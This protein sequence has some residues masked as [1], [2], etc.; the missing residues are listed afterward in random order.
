MDAPFDGAKISLCNPNG[1]QGGSYMTKI[2]YGDTPGLYFQT[3]KLETKQGII[4]TDKKHYFDI[5]I[6]SNNSEIISWVESLEECLQE[7]IYEKRK[8][9]FETELDMEDI[10]NTMTPILRPYKGGKY[11]LMRI[12]IPTVKNIVGQNRCAIYDENENIISAKEVSDNKKLIN[13]LEIQ[14]IKFSSKYFQ[15][16]IQAKQIMV[17]NEISP[18][19]SCMIRRPEE[20]NTSVETNSEP[21]VN[22]EMSSH[23]SIDKKLI[24]DEDHL[25]DTNNKDPPTDRV[26]DPPMD[27]VIDP[28]LNRV[29]DPQLDRVIDPQLNRVIDPSLDRVIDPS[30][31]RVIDHVDDP[32]IQVN[33]ENNV[34]SLSDLDTNITHSNTLEEVSID[35]ENNIEDDNVLE[36]KTKEFYYDIY[37]MALEKAKKAKRQA[38]ESFLEAKKIKETYMLDEIENDSLDEENLEDSDFEEEYEELY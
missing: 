15:V 16:D 38:L 24:S 4:I 35:L 28:P 2:K 32:K 22:I 13:I 7:K 36:L 21:I 23:E 14:G 9:W 29:I 31:D 19:K 37:R 34:D 1:I 8:L 5:M 6:D 11:H 18:F 10:Q 25:V 33:N 12:S 30:L 3:P 26:I 17:F 27:R 20:K